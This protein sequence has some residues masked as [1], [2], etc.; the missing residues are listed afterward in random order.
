M[1][2][3]GKAG[4]TIIAELH[5]RYYTQNYNQK[6]WI[7]SLTTATAIPVAATNASPQFLIWN[8][9]GSGVNVIPVAMYFGFHSGTGI[10]GAIGYSYVP[11]AGTGLA[12]GAAFS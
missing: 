7:A 9:A 4:E 12:T 10:A 2:S 11:N 6:L 8:P 5:G 1:A 3:T